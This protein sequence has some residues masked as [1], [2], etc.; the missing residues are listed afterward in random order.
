MASKKSQKDR[1][2]SRKEPSRFFGF[3]IQLFWV[4]FFPVGVAQNI[5]K[6]GVYILRKMKTEENDLIL[7]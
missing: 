7:S 6:L 1:N 4:R 2:T 5:L 3:L